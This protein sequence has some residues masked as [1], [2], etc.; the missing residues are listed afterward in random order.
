MNT[1]LKI[2]RKLFVLLAVMF[3]MAN[4]TVWAE[5]SVLSSGTWYK[6]SISET[7]M[8]KLTYSDLE[9][10]GVDVANINPKNLRIYHNG[11]GV[12]PKINNK[13]YP[14]DLYEI[15]I[16]VSGEDDG[17]FN[18]NDYVL[19]YARGPVTWRYIKKTQYYGHV[20]NPYTNYTYVFLTVGAEEGRRIQ[21]AE[22]PEETSVIPVDEFI[23][24]QVK[25]VDDI[26]INNM[27]CTWFFDKFDVVLQRNY[28][29]KFDNIN[30][31]K[32]A[33]MKV[34]MASRNISSATMT[35]K[36]DNR[37][38]YSKS[39]KNYG[40]YMF[41]DWDTLCSAR[42]AVTG[43]PINITATYNR[44]MTSS[45]AWMD[46]I[47]LN[48]WRYLKMSGDVMA[49]RNPECSSASVVY[50]YDLQNASDV[51]MVWNVTDPINPTRMKTKM[52]ASTLS[53]K[54][55]GDMNNEFIAFKGSG[56]KTPAFDGVVGNQNLHAMRDIDYLIIT[57]PKFQSHAERLKD[58]HA[59]LD[60]YVIEI[61]QPQYIY[62][63]F[64]CGAKDIAG[65]RNFVRMLYQNSSDEHSLK[66][67]LLFGDASY[68][69]H[70]TDE[71]LIPTWESFNGCDITSSVVTDDFY[72]CLDDNEGLMESPKNGPNASMIDLPIGRMPV[73]TEEQATE[74][75]DKIE[76]YVA[77]NASAMANWR[78]VITLICDDES[79]DFI[80]NSEYLA[81]NIRKWGG[82]II[83]DKIYLD[84][85]NQVATASGQRCPEINEAI[86]NRIE[87]GSL[88]VNY[89]GHGGEIGLGEER[90]LTIEDINSWENIPMLPLFVTATCEFSRYDD[91]T[92]T[93]AGE[94][95]FTNS[96]GGAIA[97]ITTARTTSGSRELLIRTYRNMFQMENGEYPTMGEIFFNAKQ[98]KTNVT[99]VFVLFGDPALRL[100]YPKNNVVL[101][102]INGKPVS[103]N[104]DTIC[105]N[106]TLK[107]LSTIELQGE[108]TDNF[109]EIMTD[110]DGVVRVSVYDKENTY[111]T[112][113]D[114]GSPVIDFK[115]RNSLLFD[116]SAT[117]EAGTFTTT[118]TIPKDINYSFGK[119][120]LSFYAT[121]YEQDANGMYD[122]IIV[123]GYNDQALP[124]EQGPEA[125]I[126]IDDT[127]FVSGG[128]TNENPLFYALMRD[129]YGINT[130]GIGIGH[131]ITMTITGATNKTYTLNSYYETPE[132]PNDYG[133]LAYRIYGLNEG[134]H[135]LNFRVWDIYNNSTN[136]SLDFV[137]IK[138]DN[139]VVENVYNSPN[140]MTNYTRFCFEHNQK[141]NIDIVI[142]IYNLSGQ[143]VKTIRDSRFGTSTRI[144]PIYWDGRGDNGANLPSGLYIYNVTLTNN[145]KE[146]HSGYSK[147]VISRQ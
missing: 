122:N 24:C 130:T 127:L 8:Y 94:L 106:D 147:L 53:F 9:S 7:G 51:E 136:V 116:G 69:Y 20:K 93:S 88:V 18:R 135:H 137:V 109:G 119:G 133:K 121:D 52:T 132:N 108:I 100:A 105:L 72:V 55:Y 90:I 46:Y 4:V 87:K 14:D 103:P 49:F 75:I 79:N 40:T 5:N 117:V 140:P 96:R 21:M 16:Y 85:Y 70:N 146:K 34:S 83:V 107:A 76:A 112:K 97:M 48:V 27:G 17:V 59:Q 26:N 28:D 19:F 102:K 1:S 38:V 86:S 123:G 12:L 41:A 77:K 6:L 45:V 42:F 92:R 99:K 125:R 50:E 145:N 37:I 118:F 111:R 65:I 67:V 144:E 36:Y 25:D 39:F 13:Y 58:I 63:E 47:S 68:D 10:M 23:D 78:N 73:K 35:F 120:L 114:E 81:N 56:F 143:L 138:S 15:P 104:N 84:A 57:H 62:N 110:F 134:E 80:S 61:V 89:N 32:E 54:V 98:D 33:K 126:F 29:F 43:S 74:I 131:D 22:E 91:H 60:D 115:L 113:G 3:F 66:Y 11:G 139:P 101:T 129:E 31:S 124:D 30:T 82:N 64:S 71:C 128:I 142:N 2:Y 44:A 141:G 95:L